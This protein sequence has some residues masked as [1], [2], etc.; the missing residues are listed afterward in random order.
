MSL[1]NDE[2]YCVTPCEQR[3]CERNIKYNPPT[4][5]LCWMTTFDDSNEDKT[6][7]SCQWKIKKR[8]CR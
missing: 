6:H 2:S 8:R 4:T 1:L 5:D 3:D 7:E